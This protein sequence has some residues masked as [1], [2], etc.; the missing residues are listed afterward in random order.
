MGK[1]RTCGPASAVG[2]EESQSQILGT[3]TCSRGPPSFPA[4]SPTLSPCHS[5]GSQGSEKAQ[6]VHVQ[7]P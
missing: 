1:G 3:R 7:H 6:G 4:G 2:P 5:P